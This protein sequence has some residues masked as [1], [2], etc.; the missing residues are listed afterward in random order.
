MNTDFWLDEI[1][2]ESRPTRE[3]IRQL[4]LQGKFALVGKTVNMYR[5]C[6]EI[7]NCSLLLEKPLATCNN[8]ICCETV[9]NVGG[10]LK[11]ARSLFNLFCR[12]VAK[13]V[14]RFCGSGFIWP[15]ESSYSNTI[16]A[17]PPPPPHPT[18]ELFGNCISSLPTHAHVKTPAWEA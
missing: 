14:A 2:W 9:V 6:C 15:L 13:H 5:F 18:Q 11:S 8:L 12:N 17:P 16:T 3:F 7:W 10:R 1:T 4:L